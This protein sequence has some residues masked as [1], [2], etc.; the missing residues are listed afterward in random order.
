MRANP[1]ILLRPRWIWDAE[2]LYFSVFHSR[3][4]DNLY[5][6]HVLLFCNIENKKYVLQCYYFHIH[7]LTITSI[8]LQIW[9]SVQQTCFNVMS[10]PTVL[11]RIWR[12]DTT[13]CVM[14]ATGI[15]LMGALVKV[16]PRQTL[17]LQTQ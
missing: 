2:S 16:S 8:T 3:L 11:M 7:S 15:L 10:M 12:E 9:M 4:C 14:M 1:P 17:V 6:L 5:Y 13:V